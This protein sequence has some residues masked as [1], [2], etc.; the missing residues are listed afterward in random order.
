M[1]FVV[2]FHL[3]D[4]QEPDLD[5]EYSV[6]VLHNNDCWGAL[7]ILFWKCEYIGFH[8]WEI[9]FSQGHF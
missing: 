7:L 9:T 8:V 3:R 6:K 1:E 2:F 5:W 4:A